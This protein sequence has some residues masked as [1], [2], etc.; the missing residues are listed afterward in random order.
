MGPGFLPA[1]EWRE[2]GDAL[3][4]FPLTLSL[5]KGVSGSRTISVYP[6]KWFDRL[7]PV[8]STGRAMNGKG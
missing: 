6:L 4:V 2:Y 8:S 3:R 5:S 7:T 1:Q